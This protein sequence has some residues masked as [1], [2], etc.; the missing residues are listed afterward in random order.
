[1]LDANA[2]EPSDNCGESEIED[3]R[4]HAERLELSLVVS[5]GV[6]SELKHPNTPRS[7]QEAMPD[8]YVIETA[9]TD[10]ERNLREAIRNLIRGNA[11]VGRHDRDADHIFECQKYGGRYFITHDSRLLGKQAGIAEI[12]PGFQILTLADF[13]AVCENFSTG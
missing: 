1:M 6:Q 4:R 2:L 8:I 5:S 7:V 10:A 9:L 13:N 3:F 12:L 11:A